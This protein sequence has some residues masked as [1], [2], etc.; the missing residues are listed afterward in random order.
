MH[1]RAQLFTRVLAYA[2]PLAGTYPNAVATRNIHGAGVVILELAQLTIIVTKR[3]AAEHLLRTAFVT[4]G[5]NNDRI[6]TGETNI[7]TAA[8]ISSVITAVIPTVVTAI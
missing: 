6:T 5:K 3:S 1:A 7:V 8:I 4:I 2:A